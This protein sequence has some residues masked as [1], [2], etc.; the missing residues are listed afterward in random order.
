MATARPA[1]QAPQDP[2]TPIERLHIWQIQAVRDVLVIA[3]AVALI[4]LGYAMRVVTVPLLIALLLAYLFEPIVSRLGSAHP[5][6]NRPIAVGA[7]M[8][9][10]GLVLAVVILLVSLAIVNQTN[11]FIADVREGRLEARAAALVERAPEEYRDLADNALRIIFGRQLEETPQQGETEEQQIEPQMD[12]DVDDS[13]RPERSSTDGTIRDPS[14]H[15][16]DEA[17]LRRIAREEAERVLREALG[18][19]PQVYT[20]ASEDISVH[21]RPSSVPFARD[22]SVVTPGP[23]GL[24]WLGVFWGGALAVLRVLGSLIALG[25][26]LF[27]I[28]FYLFFFSVAYPRIVEFGRG[29]LPERNRPRIEE[30]LG[31]M[32]R[33]VAGFVRGRI[34]VSLIMGAM[35]AVGW[36]L[37]GVPYALVLGI[38]VGLFCAV[39]FLGMIGVPVAIGLLAVEQIGLPAE[40]RMAWWGVILW[41]TLVFIVVQA[42]ESYGL[43]PIIAGKVTNLDPVTIIVAVIAGGVLMGVYGM[44]LAIPVAAC[45]KIVITDVL[46]PRI[47]AWTRG[48]AADPLPLE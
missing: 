34:I 3:A 19:Q 45:L 28:P 24:D 11:R 12:A 13:P 14:A 32:D 17:A 23:I 4:W 27:L 5:R 47:R 16:A 35:F 30:L 20:D 21:P 1:P 44:L 22:S 39:P 10:L 43:T 9:T 8:C 7:L 38:V 48:E 6:M 18:M 33:V 46:L 29:L 40:A 41:P 36:W 37:V 15:S 42:I 31:K 2:R 25:F 26:V